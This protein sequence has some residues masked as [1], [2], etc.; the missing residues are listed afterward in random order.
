MCFRS[1]SHPALRVRRLW[2][3][4]PSSFSQTVF[5]GQPGA[6][7]PVESLVQPARHRCSQ[8]PDAV[9]VAAAGL[10]VQEDPAFPC[11]HGVGR[12]VL[13]TF[14]GRLVRVLARG[15]G[16]GSPMVAAGRW[17]AFIRHGSVLGQ[18]DQL[19]ILRVTTGQVVTRLVQPGLD[20]IAVDSSGSFA[21]MTY[22]GAPAQ[23][24]RRGGFDG[25]SIGRIGH[26]GLQARAS[27]ASLL[28]AISGDRVAYE[29]PTGRCLSDGRVAIAAPGAASTSVPGLK[30]GTTLAFDGRTVAT[31]G[32]PYPKRRDGALENTVQLAGTR[33]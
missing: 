8:E 32:T 24:E 16:N 25:L 11:P 20:G 3:L 14:S 4:G 5:T 1:A 27:R 28:G 31:A 15:W 23:C 2:V 33:G 21:L 26:P 12:L 13:R 30:L 22:P 9:A 17:V 6:I 7:R 29:Q 19:Q 10:V 18:P